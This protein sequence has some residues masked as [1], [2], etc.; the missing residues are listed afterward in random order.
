MNRLVSGL[1]VG[2]VA[3]AVLGC[4]S[5]GD[6]G[7]VRVLEADLDAVR[8]ELEEAQREADEENEAT[9]AAQLAQ[10]R[11]ELLRQIAEEERR[12]AEEERDAAQEQIDDA[13]EAAAAAAASAAEAEAEAAEV[14]RVREASQRAQFFQAAFPAPANDADP[15]TLSTD[16]MM[17]SPVR[18]RLD[19]TR[20]S[21]WR[22]STLGGSGIRSTTLPLASTVNT[23][24]TVV[25]TDRE[26]SRPL[27]EHFGSLRDPENLNLL[28][29]GTPG[30]TLGFS[31]VNA[32]GESTNGVVATGV[33]PAAAWKLTHGIPTTVARDPD[34][35]NLGD[36]IVN[37]EREGDRMAKS[38][39]L[40]LFG[41]NG[42]L[43][44]ADGSDITLD[45]AFAENPDNNAQSLLGI[46]TVSGNNLRFDPSGSPSV[47]FYNGADFM[48]D[49]EYMVFGYWREDPRSPISPYDNGSIGVFAE[50]FNDTTADTGSL[51]PPD[52][53]FTAT[54]RGTAVGMYVEQEQRDPIDTHRQG[55]FVATAVLTV[56][57][58]THASITGTVRDFVTT[59]TGGSSA[60]ESADRWVVQLN[61]SN[62]VT[63]NNQSGTTTGR[64]NHAYVRAH[65]YAGLPGA[66][67]EAE[68]AI[69]HGVTGVF[70][71]RLGDIDRTGQHM[72]R[73]DTSGLHIIGAFGAV[74]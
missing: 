16:I 49:H 69:P 36:Y 56:D 73:I 58:G 42:T 30:T 22:A 9:E 65:R 63:L 17:N 48:G 67:N 13:E 4:G 54:Y 55:E 11:A 5:D 71:A 10:R 47:Y 59:P 15:P 3:L 14:I 21:G 61:A 38:Y 8:Q 29:M 43:I 44:T 26:M 34:P 24:K 35:N 64:W 33:G 41:I 25:Y 72:D 7:R 39:P 31:M 60:P 45:P 50:A 18:G 6:G 52:G 1:M 40:S 70:N 68:N 19:V 46:T 2:A 23:G 53:N 62:A 20:G 57:A 28:V 27:M 37:E 51:P 66:E 12:Q 32:D 74:R